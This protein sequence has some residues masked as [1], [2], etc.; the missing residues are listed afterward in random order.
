MKK[1]LF[2]ALPLMFATAIFAQQAK[3]LEISSEFMP[4]EFIN[5]DPVLSPNTSS[6]AAPV[7][8]FWSSDFSDPTLW[9][10][11]NDG[12]T[13]DGW[14][15]DGTTDSW[16]LPNFTSSSG[17][18]F[19]ELGNGDPNATGWNGPIQVE[20]TLTTASPINVFDSIGSSSAM[21]S[22]EEYGA[23]FND[24]QAVQVSTDGVNF[25]TIADN[26]NYTITSQS[27]GSNPYPNPSYRE[28][29]L[30]PYIVA[31]PSTVWIRFS[32]TTNYPNQA[33]NPNVWITYGWCI[34]DV[35]ISES[36]ANRITMEDEVI[37]G[38]W[39]DFLNYTPSGPNGI[40]GLD[41]SVTPLSQLQNHPY[42]IE[43]VLRNEGTASQDV[44]L[45][46]D[47]TGVATSSGS[48]SATTLAPGDSIIHS[49]TFT[50]SI[51]GTYSI[52]IYGTAD[53]AGAGMTI[54]TT[55]VV[56]KDIEVTNYIYGKDL[57]ENSP[58]SYVL[59]GPV[60]QNH[61]TT[62]FEMYANEQLSSARVFISNTSVVGAVI[63]AIIYEL[64]T[65][66]T[67]GVI[68][69]AESDN[70]ILTAQ[71]RGN[72]VDVPFLLPI[73]LFNGY[74][75][76][77]GIVGYQHPTDSSYIGLSGES[78]YNG[79]HSL[80]DEFGLSS[81]SAGTPTWYY[82]TS[83]PMVRMNF[84]PGSVGTHEIKNSQFNLYPNPTNGVFTIK[85]D[86]NAKCDV[87]VNNLLGQTVYATST[88][89]MNIT[90]DLSSFEKGIYTIE[91]KNN[92]SSYTKK[93]IVE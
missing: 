54:T 31:N 10:I 44:T 55:D 13:N 81:Q 92:K 40:Y 48:S 36:P 46:Y 8:P 72:W 65:A 24:L 4:S 79:E 23:R 85:L 64:D 17:G 21:L 69:L 37:G 28:V 35:Q 83:T 77:F 60:D 67:D 80:F 52:D 58:G 30:Q 38:Y 51:T 5:I 76:E 43:A 45:N 84:D 75:Y 18:S 78:L 87:T 74:A 14:S 90:I 66:A 57:G 61:I 22:F 27:A 11:D 82:I 47:V 9:S 73:S 39:I 71:D 93:V 62:R 29:N 59:G 2:L 19:A 16:Y 1:V 41:Y 86:G 25:T 89:A 88:T 70:Y 15:I 7:A 49:T 53:S 63:K 68:F 33:T 34:D 12:Q 3:F 26:L 20:Y 91:L 32:W 42:A 50:P 56:S 6:A